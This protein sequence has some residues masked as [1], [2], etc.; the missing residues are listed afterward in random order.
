MQLNNDTYQ[1]TFTDTGLHI[2]LEQSDLDYYEHTEE[3]P[4]RDTYV[5]MEAVKHFQKSKREKAGVDYINA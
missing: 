4:S 5:A 3:V 1:V 2:I